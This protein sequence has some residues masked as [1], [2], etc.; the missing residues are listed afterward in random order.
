MDTVSLRGVYSQEANAE[1]EEIIASKSYIISSDG[2]F[3]RV[4]K[5][6]AILALYSLTY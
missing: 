3:A 2:S 5:N 4:L 6:E 1:C